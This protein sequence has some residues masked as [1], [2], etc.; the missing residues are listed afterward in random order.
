MTWRRLRPVFRASPREEAASEIAF[1]IEERTRELIDA[2]VD[3]ATARRLAEERFGPIAPIERAIE[4][5]TRR[6]R[7][8]A[9][10]TEGYMN[11]TQDLRYGVRVLRRNPVFAAAAIATLTLGVG[12]ALAVF[13]VVNGVLLRPMPY[14]D[15]D[16]ISMIW[17]A[18]RGEDGNVYELPLTSG[19]FVDIERDS[20]S[21][22]SLAA[23]R[24]W[25]Y[26]IA[27]A[28]SADPEPVSG[29]RVSPALF[30]VLGVRPAA[31]RAFTR[32]EAV[33]GAPNVAVISHDLWQ[34][35]FGGDRGIVGRQVYLNG[36]PFTVTGIMPRGF[37]FPRGAELPAPFG[38]GLRTDVWTPLVFDAADLQS[39]D[40]NNLSAVGRLAD[41]GCGNTAGC[42]APFAQAE[43]TGMMKRFLA[44]NAPRLDFE[45]KLVSMT[46]QAANRV[47]K[48]LLILLGAVAFVLLIAAANVTSLLVAR[49]HARERE[50][51]VRSALGAAR[52]RIARQLVTENLVLCGLGTALGLVV[53]H[54][55][56]KVMLAL[57]PG[58]L[59]R[60]DDI[61]LDW[62]VLS[63]A[64]ALAVLAAA[65][66]GI[67]A[68][69]AVRW[70]DKGPAAPISNAL[71]T[72]DTRAA[73]SVRRRSARQFLVATEVALSLVLLIGAAL[74]TRSFVGLQQVRPGFDPTNVITANVSI[75]IAGRFQP[76]VDGP[77]WSATFDQ[78]TTRLASVPGVAAAGAVSSLPV[79]GVV[80]FGGVGLA[81]RVY[82]AGQVPSALYAVVAGEYFRAAGIRLIT[83]RLFDAS[84]R[85]P[86]GA[87]I[88]VNRTYA[89]E[90][91]GSET[92]AV[93]R[94]VRPTFEFDRARP[95]RTIVGV[96]DDVKQTSLDAEPGSQVYVPVT[97]FP[98][99]RLTLVVRVADGDPGTAVPV[100]RK[101]VREVNPAATIDDV[102]TM[103]N[104]V[105]ESL[106]RQRFQMTLIGTFAVL[107][108]VL[109]TVGLYGVLALTVGQRR[110]EIGVRL[111]LGATPRAVVGMLV[112]EGA[113]IAAV[114]VVLGLAGA[115]ALTRVLRSLLY[116][117]SSTDAPTFT[118][119]AV[120]VAAVALVATWMPARRAAR[121]D[122]RAALASE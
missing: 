23:F 61:G 88:I 2:G 15:P 115:F 80:E 97:Q 10:R 72:G 47:R 4:D 70:R 91:F 93:G 73:G 84:D 30:D 102:R 87:T 79:S 44:A 114:G 57:V 77:Q 6:R 119:A 43:L 101:A 95:P 40:V 71:H 69:Y 20:R 83:G 99:P 52:G 98:Y 17:I 76:A 41:S 116:G 108:L 110:R 90:Q 111:A 11:L 22:A 67:A 118:A 66:F 50:L 106:A 3:P 45:Y 82:E 121:V 120:F 105:S 36:A 122:P 19:F 100:I 26:A 28:R 75:P 89:R 27:D 12:A 33:P 21:F 63:L 8:R 35:K 74:L 113:R 9:D 29:A 117:I 62:R 81:G 32:A 18:T 24:A 37:S 96:V 49:A 59:P 1:H 39:Y 104:V 107:A 94:Q 65:G 51:A 86:S 25:R 46:D 5:S 31:G 109:A 16:R 103:E 78:V 48:P 60:A 64:G 92:N 58:S 42:S 54:W 56:T 7:Q 68:A 85:D 53:A 38:F 112:G 55:G 13:N 14:K 34:R